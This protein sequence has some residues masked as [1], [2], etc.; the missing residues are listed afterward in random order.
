MQRWCNFYPIAQPLQVEPGD[1]VAV[2]VD[3]R[4]LLHAVTWK[5]AV[6]DGAGAPKSVARQST[7]LGEFLS[8]ADL[9]HRQGVA[10][11]ASALGKAIARG[12]TLADGSRSIDE[13]LTILGRE[14]GQDIVGGANNA[15]VRTLL[16]RFTE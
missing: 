5:T 3:V 1:R 9:E 12:L 8:P 13:I 2:E 14:F 6:T 11:R 15:T 10:V 4:P 16:Q 7:L